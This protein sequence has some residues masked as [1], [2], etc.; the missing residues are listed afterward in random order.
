MYLT[1]YTCFMDCVAPFKTRIDFVKQKLL[2]V[3]N[4]NINSVIL[5]SLIFPC[6]PV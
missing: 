2:L 4:F 5:I 1:N 3:L 6:H